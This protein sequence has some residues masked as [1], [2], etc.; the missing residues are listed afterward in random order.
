MPHKKIIIIITITILNKTPQFMFTTQT[1]D[2]DVQLS[3]RYLYLANG[4]IKLILFKTKF[5]NVS[6]KPTPPEIF[7]ISINNY[8]WPSSCSGQK[9]YRVN[10]TF[11]FYTSHSANKQILYSSIFKIYSV[12][13][14]T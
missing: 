2:F 11:S 8:S 14:Y 1:P 4:N 13:N 3:P 12:F 6:N 5:M 9:L 10:F 7:L